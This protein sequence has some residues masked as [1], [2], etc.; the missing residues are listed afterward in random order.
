MNL[1]CD[2]EDEFVKDQIELLDSWE[3]AQQMD[4]EEP[5]EESSEVTS[6]RAENEALN[7]AVTVS[8]TKLIKLCP[9]IPDKLLKM[10]EH[11]KLASEHK[12]KATEILMEI[13]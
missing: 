10:M 13:G 7:E 2:T 9:T 3:E 5:E 6:E 11:F 12:Q 8:I 1:T 4:E